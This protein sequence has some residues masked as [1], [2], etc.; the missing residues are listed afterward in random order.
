VGEQRRNSGSNALAGSDRT[1][2]AQLYPTLKNAQ[3][4][5]ES[6]A[7]TSQ[8]GNLKIEGLIAAARRRQ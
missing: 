2:P 8:D 7:G 4:L 3:A 5:P 1:T 6:T